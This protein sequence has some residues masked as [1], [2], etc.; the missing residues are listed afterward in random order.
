MSSNVSKSS[1][2]TA[3]KLHNY[4]HDSPHLALARGAQVQPSGKG[5]PGR[6][7]PLIRHP[8][9]AVFCSS[10]PNCS[11]ARHRTI[12]APCFCQCRGGHENP[13]K[14]HEPARRPEQ[15]I[16][17][18]LFRLTLQTFV[19][20]GHSTWET[21]E[22]QRCSLRQQC[23]GR[24][25]IFGAL[26][27]HS[28][29][30]PEARKS[31]IPSPCK[32]RTQRECTTNAEPE[33]SSKTSTVSSHVTKTVFSMSKPGAQ[34]RQGC[35]QP[36]CCCGAALHLQLQSSIRWAALQSS[37]NAI[38]SSLASAGVVLERQQ[39]LSL[40]CPPLQAFEGS[41]TSDGW[42]V[43]LSSNTEA[44]ATSNIPVEGSI[45]DLKC[46]I[47]SPAFQNLL[48]VTPLACLTCGAGRLS[49][50]SITCLSTIA[51]ACRLAGEDT[52]CILHCSRLW[53]RMPNA[54]WPP[55]TN[56]AW[57]ACERM[58]QWQQPPSAVL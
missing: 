6:P 5:M 28:G 7:S 16:M 50:R 3:G 11:T 4:G 40:P 42:K 21:S 57:Q 43:H 46:L 58:L 10:S 35:V 17:C 49:C 52:L 55:G 53:R 27:R 44:L 54:S 22:H 25:H 56:P 19:R 12:G 51:A 15:A 47:S 32:L 8:E 13:P 34:E 24:G 14:E 2:G 33:D 9:L 20:P 31:M 1:I 30:P 29:E 45:S 26:R 18:S 38:Y 37:S 36:G 39:T 23:I 48:K 41:A